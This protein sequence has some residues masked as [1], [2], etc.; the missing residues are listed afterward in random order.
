MKYR[1]ILI[2]QLKNIPY[3]NKKTI[4]QISEQYNL[5]T[6]TVDTYISRSL[7]RKEL[8]QLKKGMYVT[9][10]YF[11]KN[12]NDISYTFYL[13]NALRQP[14]YV[15]L[16]TTLQYYNLT[17]E[18][19]HS[20]ISV[21]PKITRN[22]QNKAGSFAYHS[23]KKTLFSDFSLIKGNFNFFIATPAKALFDLIYFKTNQFRSID[24]KQ[25]ELL[26]DDLRIDIDEMDKKERDNFYT[27]IKNHLK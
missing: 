10:D 3:F 26:I 1:E 16:W 12:K 15:S 13:A 27:T 6:G 9:A 22:Y 7:V 11:N 21:T 17:T 23:I 4:Y 20:V 18:A 24:L 5:K 19:V 25:V 8:I 14:S 2:A